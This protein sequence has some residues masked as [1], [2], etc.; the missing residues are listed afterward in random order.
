MERASKRRSGTLPKLDRSK[1]DAEYL[2]IAILATDKGGPGKVAWIAAG[3][4]GII[5]GIARA[6]GWGTKYSYHTDGGLYQSIPV[7][8]PEGPRES[9]RLITGYPP[10]PEIKGLL[11]FYSVDIGIEDRLRGFPFKRRYESIFV[12]P[13]DGRVSFQLGLLEPGVPEALGTIEKG[14]ENHFRLIT[15]TEPWIVLWNSAGFVTSMHR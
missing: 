8:T 10:I 12:R 4:G 13:L 11:R 1:L 3:S 6:H 15:K 5:F 14:R 7:Q 9:Q 2:R